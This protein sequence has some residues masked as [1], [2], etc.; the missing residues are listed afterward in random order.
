[1]ENIITWKEVISDHGT[2]TGV[3]IK[4]NNVNSI[5]CNANQDGKYPNVVFD[6]QIHYFTGPT[7]NP[8]GVRA[9]IKSCESNRP[10]TVYLKLEKNKW[11]NLGSFVCSQYS[12]NNDGFTK[13]NLYPTST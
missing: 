6:D 2:I 12:V 5:L 3:S 8:K 4:N 1:M 10:F 7:T 9:L 13:F 11:R